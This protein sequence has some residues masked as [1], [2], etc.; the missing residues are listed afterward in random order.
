[1][2]LGDFA[3]R[4]SSLA[5]RICSIVLWDPKQAILPVYEAS[6]MVSDA[7]VF[8]SHQSRIALGRMSCF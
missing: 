2:A 7:E 1:M 3:A 8:H 5:D 4:R 6:P